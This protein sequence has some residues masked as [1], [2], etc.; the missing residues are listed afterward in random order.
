MRFLTEPE[1]GRR[2]ETTGSVQRSP[3]GRVP[4]SRTVAVEAK[5]RMSRLA[6][7]ATAEPSQRSAERSKTQGWCTP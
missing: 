5:R 6:N 4:R 7:V 1:P 2:C 3:G